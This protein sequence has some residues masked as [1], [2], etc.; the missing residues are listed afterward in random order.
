[1]RKILEIH[2]VKDLFDINEF[3]KS[4]PKP[5]YII[6]IMNDLDFEGNLWI[7]IGHKQKSAFR[8][9]LDGQKHILKNLKIDLLF[10]ENIG[11]IFKNCGYIH[12]VYLD[13]T[14]YIT[15]SN[16][17]GSI[18]GINEGVI[19]NCKSAANINGYDY[20]G[21]ICGYTTNISNVFEEDTIIEKSSFYGKINGH[22]AIGGI[23]GSFYGQGMDLINAGVI[24]GEIYVGGICGDFEGSSNNL[25][26][27]GSVNGKKYVGGVYG[28]VKNSTLINPENCGKTTGKDIFGENGGNIEIISKHY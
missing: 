2:T 22:E 18:C 8:G 6:K 15:G 24:N 21:G 3:I 12:N 26:N 5:D 17:I 4:N 1:M 11:L 28:T 16:Y 25:K 10:E 23:C 9:E 19:S 7:P 14:C 27:T 20:I 13:N